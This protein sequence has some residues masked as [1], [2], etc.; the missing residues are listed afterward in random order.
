MT[1]DMHFLLDIAR[2]KYGDIALS[3]RIAPSS[4]WGDD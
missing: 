2:E 3:I 4:R 1:L